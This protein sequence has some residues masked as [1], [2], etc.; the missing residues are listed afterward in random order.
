VWP[1]SFPAFSAVIPVY[2]DRKALE[3]AIPL[4]LQYLSEISPDFELIIAEDG[5][6]DGSAGLV[7][8]FA[9]KDS[10]V[11]L[12]HSDERL[13]RGRALYRAFRDSRAPI[14]LYYD[15]DL[16]TGMEHLKELIGAI[17]EEGYDIATGSRLLPESR[18]QRTGGRE[19]ASRGYNFLVRSVLGSRIHDHQCGFKSF[20]RD[21]IVPLAEGV[22]SFHW[23]WDTE[24]LVRAE[25]AGYRIKEF[26]VHWEQGPGTTVRK[27]DVIG[28]GLS[29]LRLWWQ[30]HVQE[31]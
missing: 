2:N 22:R 16:A 19:F 30:I 11:R 18:I 21:R 15:V 17:N 29:V 9:K 26:P 31:S 7:G 6:T 12:L 3:R 13:G 25:R 23:F 10:R 1:L 20:R 8:D 24:I 28:M 14:V 27:S 5:S 4:S